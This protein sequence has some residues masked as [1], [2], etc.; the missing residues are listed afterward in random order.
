MFLKIITSEVNKLRALRNQASVVHV[1]SAFAK[2]GANT[3]TYEFISI[4]KVEES[5]FIFI[6]RTRLLVAQYF[7]TASAL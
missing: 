5:I 2:P 7:F 4:F 3:A 1:K 6:K